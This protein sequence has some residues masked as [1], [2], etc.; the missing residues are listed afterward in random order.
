M[1]KKRITVIMNDAKVTEELKP[2]RKA[3]WAAKR[4]G[5]ARDKEAVIVAFKQVLADRGEEGTTF[6]PPVK[7]LITRY[8]S[9]KD[10][11]LDRDNLYATLK[12][13]IDGITQALGLGYTNK[14]GR[15]VGYDDE[16][17]MLIPP[18]RQ[19]FNPKG[20]TALK[21]TVVEI[22]EEELRPKD[23]TVEKGVA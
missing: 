22:T 21:F 5:V 7:L 23:E 10:R 2:N 6:T 8:Y 4:A 1:E 11:A 3:H 18:P 9:G 16:K 15:W 20:L 12:A 13:Y 14:A 17:H 19:E